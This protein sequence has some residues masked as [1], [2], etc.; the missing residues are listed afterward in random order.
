MVYFAINFNENIVI[1]KVIQLNNNIIFLSK[2]LIIG[3]TTCF[4]RAQFVI[5]TKQYSV[6][7]IPASTLNLKLVS[8]NCLHETAFLVIS[9][10]S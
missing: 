6:N 1:G 4:K 5:L 3:S 2:N 9:D 8:G 7:L 10:N